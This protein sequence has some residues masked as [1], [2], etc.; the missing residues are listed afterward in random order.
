MRPILIL[1]LAALALAACSQPAPAASAGEPPAPPRAAATSGVPPLDADG[2]P[3]FRPGLYEVVQVSDGE[4]PETTRQ[5][6]GAGA[7]DEWRDILTRKPGPECKISRSSGAAGLQVVTECRQ[8]GNTNRLRLTLA[9]SETAY[10]MTL[11]I[12]V[13]T[14]NGETSSMESTAQARWLGACSESIEEDG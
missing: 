13:T 3:R 10:R 9:G 4:P 14:P 6:L 8:N 7:P 2:L 11:K 12:A 1:P 5:C